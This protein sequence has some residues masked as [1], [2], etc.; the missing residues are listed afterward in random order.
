LRTVYPGGYSFLL[1]LESSIVLEEAKLS[2]LNGAD[3]A[4]VMFAQA[5]IEHLLQI[6]VDNLGQPKVARRGLKAIAAYVRETEPQHAYLMGLVDEVR[7]FR[8]PFMHLR[9]FDD[10]D[11]LTQR[12]LANP[13]SPEQ[14]LEGEAKRALAIMYRVALT[15]F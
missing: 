12:L 13:G 8:N 15:K 4:T 1:P 6:H 2:F 9:E 11:R 3:L 10:P 14:V 7:R 5:F